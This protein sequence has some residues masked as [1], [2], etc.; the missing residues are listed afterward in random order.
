MIDRRVQLGAFAIA[1]LVLLRLV[2]G[3]HFFSEGVGKFGYDPSQGGYALTFSAAP[4]LNQAKGP[5]APWFH[6]QAPNG[7]DWAALLAVPKRGVAPSDEEAAEHAKWLADY[8]RRRKEAT[9]KKEPAP[10]EFPPFAPYHDWATRVVADWTALVDRASAVDGVSD[11][12]RSAMTAALAARHQQLADYLAGEAEAIAD[13]QH[14]LW[15]LE[16]LRSEPEADGLPFQEQRIAKK[17]AETSGQPRAWVNQVEAFEQGLIQD[18]RYAVAGTPEAAET[19]S[20]AVDEALVSPDE[21][22]LRFVNV[23]VTALTLGVG[24]CLL[25]GLLTRMAAILGALFLLSVIATQP[26]WVAD[27]AP[28][29]N[30]CVE[31][32]GLLVLAGTGAGRWLGLDYFFYAWQNGCCGRAG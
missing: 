23:A 6:S 9:A 22:W 21:S 11:E 1:A 4:F 12:Q 8:E 26:P 20:A 10:I 30:Q 19:V 2:V 17:A 15:R 14:E 18:V 5:L 31:F 32:A 29:I 28:T 7:H 25:L 3:W 27:A 24:V 13:Y 16:N